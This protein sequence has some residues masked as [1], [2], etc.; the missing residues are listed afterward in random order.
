MRVVILGSRDGAEGLECR[1]AASADAAARHLNQEGWL[2]TPKQGRG[3]VDSRAC[4]P[5]I[6]TAR[7]A[8]LLITVDLSALEACELQ[9]LV[10]DVH[11]L[12]KLEDEIFEGQG[13]RRQELLG[14]SRAILALHED[15]VRRLRGWGRF[16]MLLGPDVDE[17]DAWP[18]TSVLGAGQLGAWLS[19][20]AAKGHDALSL[21]SA[22]R[23]AVPH[24]ASDLKALE[25]W[26]LTSAGRVQTVNLQHV[27]LAS[28]SIYFRELISSADLVTADG[29]P[30]VELLEGG[31]RPVKRVTGADLVMNVLEHPLAK[32]ARLALIGGAHAPGEAFEAAAEQAGAALVMREHGDKA[33]WDPALL[34]GQM[35]ERRVRLALVAVTQPAGDQL[36]AALVEAGYAGAVIGI[37]AAVELHVGSERRA[38]SVL[39]WLRLEWF[40][41]FLQDPKRLWRRYFIEGIPTYI[42][43]VRPMARARRLPGSAEGLS[44]NLT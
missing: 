6:A 15:D 14:R 22:F 13:P 19:Q 39:Q 43:L 44:K 37:G 28:R 41:R 29:W 12:S 2:S 21:D 20:R 27:F 4:G 36:A 26:C 1:E 5:W 32:G 42:Q 35:N 30:I 34:A 24:V 8:D 40:F 25:E 3:S 16:P 9:G 33:D 11:V 18:N 7:S 31:D 17:V 38:S 23:L 10:S